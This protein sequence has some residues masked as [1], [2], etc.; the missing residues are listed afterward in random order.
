[1]STMTAPSVPKL[2]PPTGAP[3]GAPSSAWALFWRGRAYN[4]SDLTGQ[5]L[6][7]LALLTGSDDY[8]ALDINPL[9]GHQRLMQMLTAFVCVER[10]AGI[11]DP[12]MA[13][14][15]MAAAIQEVAKASVDE[16]LGALRRA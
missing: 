15:E 9:A 5:H 10:T 2:P 3:V 13:G 1:M 16:I 14:D 8:E 11:D 4:E 12:A 7:F 6:A